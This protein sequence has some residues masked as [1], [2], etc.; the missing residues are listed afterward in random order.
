ME[1]L[2]LHCIMKCI[3]KYCYYYDLIWCCLRL[4]VSFMLLFWPHLSRFN[5]NLTFYLFIVF[6]RTFSYLECL[7]CCF[8]HIVLAF[9]NYFIIRTIDQLVKHIIVGIIDSENKYEY[10][11]LVLHLWIK[12]LQLPYSTLSDVYTH[13]ADLQQQIHFETN[14]MLPRI[15]NIT[16]NIMRKC[17]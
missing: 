17:F 2:S 15:K 11:A 14:T 13:T 12:K 10:T 1:V 9:Y 8:F 16:R 3:F 7:D 6:I 4:V 5:V